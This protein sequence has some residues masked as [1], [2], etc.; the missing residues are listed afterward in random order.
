[1]CVKLLSTQVSVI[2][3]HLCSWLHSVLAY[4]HV[5]ITYRLYCSRACRL[6]SGFCC[7]GRYCSEPT[8][9]CFL[10]P[11]LRVPQGTALVGYTYFQ[12]PWFI[13]NCFPKCFTNLH[14]FH[15]QIRVLI[16]PNAHW[17]LI[18]ASL[19]SVKS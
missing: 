12:L 4:K 16:V 15:H 2:L 10:S 17:P 1:M 8:C 5:V 6:L 9:T 14:N 3:V 13:F 11:C 7:Y 19:L 18:S